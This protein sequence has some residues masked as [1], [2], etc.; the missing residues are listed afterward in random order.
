MYL[1]EK[2]KFGINN[3]CLSIEYKIISSEAV[4]HISVNK[5]MALLLGIRCPK[6]KAAPIFDYLKRD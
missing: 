4:K 2:K 6:K 1:T 5:K 3:I